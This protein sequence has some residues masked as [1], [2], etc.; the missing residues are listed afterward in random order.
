MK[1]LEDI[2]KK[3]L[4]EVPE[5]YF[6]RLPGVIQARVAS[7]QPESAWSGYGRV[8][9]RFA[10]PVVVIAAAAVFFLNNPEA[11]ST[12]ELLASIE[13]EQLVAY[14]EETEVNTDDLLEFAPLE[15]EEV[16]ALEED[17]FGEYILEEIDLEELENEF[18]TTRN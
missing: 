2:P 5:G 4:F 14:L 10:L 6:D 15:A 8:A 3:T 16:Q 1:R 18:D 17:A 7:Q 12:E 13:S 9:L 11:A